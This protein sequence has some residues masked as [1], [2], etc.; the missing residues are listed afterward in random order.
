M[1]HSANWWARSMNRS[2]HLLSRN[3][4][5]PNIIVRCSIK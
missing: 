2:S 1:L 5:H 4:A 3:S